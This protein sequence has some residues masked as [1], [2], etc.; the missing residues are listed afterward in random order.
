MISICLNWIHTVPNHRWNF[1]DNIRTSKAFM[2]VKN[3]SGKKLRYFLDFQPV[4]SVFE[5]HVWFGS[6]V[7][8][9]QSSQTVSLFQDVIICAACA[10]PG[11]GRNP[12]TPRF[13]RHFS[14]FSIPTSAEH[15]LKHIFKVRN[16]VG[17][18][19]YST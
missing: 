17:K 18:C 11:G 6:T 14:M 13:I 16:I 5:M 2:I 7:T 12:V 19:T 1:C 15:T 4:S 3:F 9:T 10:P 8:I